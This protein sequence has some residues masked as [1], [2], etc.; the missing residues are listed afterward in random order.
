MIKIK[1]MQTATFKTRKLPTHGEWLQP[2]MHWLGVLLLCASVISLGA[3]DSGSGE[4]I[5]PGIIEVPVAYIKRPIP[6]EVM[7]DEVQEG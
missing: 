4:G 1:M 3:C 7:D 6:V 5:D 2:P